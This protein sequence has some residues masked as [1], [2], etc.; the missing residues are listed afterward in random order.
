[1]KYSIALKFNMASEIAFLTD[2]ELRTKLRSFNLTD[3]PITKTTRK[4]FEAKLARAMGL[5]KQVDKP[6]ESE[7]QE[8]KNSSDQGAININGLIEKDISVCNAIG[9][10]EDK[11]DKQDT[12]NKQVCTFYGVCLDSESESEN[13]GAKCISVFTDKT[14]TLD[15][16][17]KNK[18]KGVRFR[19]FST[20]NEAEAFA[21]GKLPTPSRQLS[22]ELS[23]G[24]VEP[25][26]EYKTPKPGEITN[27]RKLIEKGEVDSVAKIIYG[28]PKFLISSLDTP[29]I[30]QQGCH[31]NSMHVASKAG[32]RDICKLIIETL[33]DDEFWKL[34]YPVKENSVN[35][36][37]L[38][39][40][41]KAFLLD[42]YLN[43]P[44]KGVSVII[45]YMAVTK[46]S[47][48]SKT[49]LSSVFQYRLYRVFI[50]QLTE[51]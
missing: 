8:V 1:M 21:S 50:S 33:N 14:Q 27:Y 7:K 9:T 11:D 26:S 45:T 42:L 24:P 44:D 30:I 20:R 23:P 38:N 19:P 29:F 28:N 6:V 2:E 51:L 15:F 35:N 25:T 22:Q 17:K 46:I 18:D 4:L 36:V 39:N 3:G 10:K 47:F 31:Y 34:M 48:W 40:R 43:T 13:V 16:V 12:V 37:Q 5:N 32:H 49:S 41:R